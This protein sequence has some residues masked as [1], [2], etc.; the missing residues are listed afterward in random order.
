MG[1]PI[2]M[3]APVLLNAGTSLT[4]W[5]GVDPG[6]VSLT[7]SQITGPIQLGAQPITVM[8]GVGSGPATAGFWDYTGAFSVPDKKGLEFWI[9]V[10][11]NGATVKN[12]G[13][14]GAVTLFNSNFSQSMVSRL[15]LKHGWNHAMTARTDYAPSGGATWATEF[16]RIRFRLDATA[17]LTHSFWMTNLSYSGFARSQHCVMFDDGYSSVYDVA[18]PLMQS[19]GQVGTVAVIA[20]AVGTPGFMTLAQLH[21]L[22]DAGWAIV[23][24]TVNHAPG[25]FPWLINASKAACFA[26][27]Q[28]GID[29]L[30][31]N[32]FTRDNEHLYF[33]SPGGEWSQNYLDAA[34]DAGVLLFRGLWGDNAA[35]TSVPT[36]ES[37]MGVREPY[38]ACSSV[39]SSWN[40]AN[41]TGRLD[42]MASSGRSGIWLFHKIETPANDTIKTTIADFTGAMRHAYRKK[43]Q[44][45]NVTLPQYRAALYDPLS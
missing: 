31:A 29:Y 32:G 18:F 13:V 15:R 11:M 26:E 1:R 27:I 24:H 17:G 5:A 10:D 20:S 35:D 14:G 12:S 19:L 3:V 2:R 39:V 28:G 37:Y 33:I 21:E 30:V 38:V 25:G 23:N 40:E 7:L 6:I 16:N 45:D 9:Y 41:L 36:A 22:H 34:N 8:H 43:A 44:I 4:G 42:K